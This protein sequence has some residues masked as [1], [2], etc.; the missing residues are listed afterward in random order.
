[1]SSIDFPSQLSPAQWEAV[2]YCDGPSL[3]IAGAG[4]GK[5]RMLTY[6]IAYLIHCGL[7]PWAI[8]ALTFTNK[9][10]R[11]MNGR[12]EALLGDGSTEGMWSGTFHSIFARILRREAEAIG[13]TQRFTIYDADDSKTLIKQIIKRRGL[14]DKKYRPGRIASRISDAKNRLVVPDA[15]L[16]DADQR[17]RDLVSDIPETGSIYA[18]YQRTLRAADAMDFDDLLLNTFLLFRDRDDIRRRYRERFGYILVD[19]YQDT[20]YA[21]HRI[22]TQLAD[23]PQSRICVVGDDAQSIYSFRGA[24]IDN[25]LGFTKQYE[26]CRLFKLERN[27]RST[28]TIVR[29]A[30]SIIA[31]NK[32]QIPKTVYSEEAEGDR[33]RVIDAAND[34]EESAK[35]AK[36]IQRLHGAEHEGW[37]T[38]AVLYRTNA[39]SRSFEDAFSERGIPYRVYGGLSFY[40]R[41]EIKDLIAYMRLLVNPNDDVA[42]RRV[43][44]VPARGIG[45]TTVTRLAEAAAGA[46]CSL[47]EAAEH[48]EQLQAGLSTATLRKVHGFLALL[49][50]LRERLETVS[51]LALATA[52]LNESGLAQE[53]A[54]DKSVEGETRQENVDSLFGAIAQYEEDHRKAHPDAPIAPLTDYLESVALLTDADRRDDGT[55][56]VTVMTIHAAK[57]LEFDTVFVTGLEDGL[58]PA[59]NSYIDPREREEERRLFYVAVTRAGKRCYLTHAD[60]RFRFGKTE[61]CLPSPFLDEIAGDCL[62]YGTR[63]KSHTWNTRP[64][65]S[66]TPPFA[67]RFGSSSRGFSA[68]SAQPAQPA[69]RF[70]PV[71]RTPFP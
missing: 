49:V 47:W 64:S 3:V 21:Q 19:E 53:L 2:Q 13:Y 11:E 56:R 30:A 70:R 22:V 28:K 51:A 31:N 5:T 42:F 32:R 37:E 4:S 33:L 58:F 17:K 55:P 63:E 50:S 67:S 65:A 14:D 18:E 12:I 61:A 27:Y 62:S 69:P 9:A 6:K 44:N 10:A 54:A 68:P 45:Q 20:N 38:M 26:G 15:Y 25:I 34:K 46:A 52:V 16:A 7:K 1:M 48:A 8:L 24:N 66:L 39:Q 43:I 29:A 71:G 23:S 40:Q 35:V 41:K 57:G 59:N 36:I 60:K